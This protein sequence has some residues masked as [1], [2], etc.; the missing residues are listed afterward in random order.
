MDESA[1]ALARFL[2]T[3]T[4]HVMNEIASAVLWSAGAMFAAVVG[5]WIL[6]EDFPGRLLAF[7]AALVAGG[8][9]LAL[10]ADKVPLPDP[11]ARSSATALE[12][13]R[14]E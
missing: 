11:W 2:R 1:L 8:A 13:R 5:I 6:S 12:D 14:A 7:N 10:R 9:Y 3:S 4:V